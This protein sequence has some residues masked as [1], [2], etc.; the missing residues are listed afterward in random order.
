MTFEFHLSEEDYLTQLLFNANH[1]RL[2]KRRRL[3]TWLFCIGAF[4][5][6]AL[7]FYSNDNYPLTISYTVCAVLCAILYPFY[8]RWIYKRS[9]RKYLKESL[10][11]KRDN[12]IRVEFKSDQ[13]E[14]Q[15][16]SGDAT[17]KISAIDQIYETGQYFFIRFDGSATLILPKAHFD[18]TEFKGVIEQIIESYKTPFEQDLNWRWK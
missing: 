14:L 8:Q 15:D 9:Y 12:L 3:T 4:L 11:S 5:L 1:S 13:I 17:I 10:K 7:V 6:M 2:I 16:Y 18:N